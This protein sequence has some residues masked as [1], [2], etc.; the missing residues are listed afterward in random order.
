MTAAAVGPHVAAAS[1]IIARVIP[2]IPTD[3][4]WPEHRALD[5]SIMTERKLWPQETVAKLHPLLALFVD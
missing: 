4:S 1:T 3:A 2:R 5:G